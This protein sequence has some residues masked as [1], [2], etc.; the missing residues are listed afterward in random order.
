VFRRNVADVLNIEEMRERA[1]WLPRAVFDAI[2]G[3]AS[4]EI[5]LRANRTA[6][7]KLWLRPRAL[8]D[9]SKRN[10]ATTAL[11]QPISMP[12]ML[13][14]CGFG[15]MANSQ[16]ELAVARA[17][18][19]FGTV[20]GVSGSASYS[21]EDIA[22]VATGP[23]WYQMYLPET[24][25]ATQALLDRVKGAGYEVLCVTI[26]TPVTPKRERD[27]RNKLTMPLQFSPSLIMTGLSN[28]VWAKDFMLGR[29]G[30]RGAAGHIFGG[31]RTAYW[32]F[33]RIVRNV[34]PVTFP[35]V[36][37]L[38]DHWQGKL[39]IK[40]VM[41]GD[42]CPQ[43]VKVGVDG[44]QVS[45]HGGR[46]LDCVRATIDILPEVLA[47]VDG[48][49]E[50]FVDGGIRRGT[51]VV[52]AIALGAKACL[53]GRP[54]LFGLAAGGEAGVTRVLEIFRNEIEHTMAMAGCASVADI[55]SSLVTHTSPVG[56]PSAGAVEAV[57]ALR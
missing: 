48:K 40:G 1:K 43:M 27:Y 2:D 45:N 28:P 51:D 3:G 23:L 7:E 52:K 20:F 4:D 39:V 57:A 47:A 19:R 11:G 15:R 38:R 31:V 5:T 14:P 53:I 34:R 54:Y 13:A 29:V 49:V 37:W 35:D 55:D 46:N 9:V 18:G 12:L 33:A 32:N 36:E 16:A 42:E 41:R 10:L 6:Y 21:P 22:K 44:I 50:V 30:D 8:A 25:E 17:A 24:R 56:R 26:D